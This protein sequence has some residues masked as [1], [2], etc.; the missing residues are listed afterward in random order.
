MHGLIRLKTV[1]IFIKSLRR[2]DIDAVNGC[3]SYSGALG[4]GI[5]YS[6]RRVSWMAFVDPL[7]CVTPTTLIAPEVMLVLFD[8]G[9]STQPEATI[10]IM[11]PKCHDSLTLFKE[12]FCLLS[13]PMLLCL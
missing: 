4:I 10:A 2:L 11:K 6:G 8:R 7:A 3:S 12:L 5:P 9:Y 13:M 1:P